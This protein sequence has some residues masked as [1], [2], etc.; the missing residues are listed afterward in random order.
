MIQASPFGKGQFLQLQSA[1][2]VPISRALS[3]EPKTRLKQA[4][5]L[6]F[7]G[8]DVDLETFSTFVG[9]LSSRLDQ[10]SLRQHF[11]KGVQKVDAGLDS[12]G[13]HCENGKDLATPDLCW[14]YCAKAAGMGS[15]TTL[16]DGYRVWDALSGDTQK[17]F[18]KANI[19]Y[20][21]TLPPSVWK[22]YIFHERPEYN[23]NNPDEI[24]LTHLQQFH[25][26]IENL[27]WRL[28][29]DLSLYTEHYAPAAHPTLFGT[30][31]AFANNIFSPSFNVG[32]PQTLW[33]NGEPL[34]PSIIQEITQVTGEMTEEV[35]WQDNDVLLIDNSRV[36]H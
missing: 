17:A 24:G 29:D 35:E 1:T 32:K 30:R 28:N 10:D 4:G 2:S 23:L 9:L 31:L 34:A 20:C 14:F 25:A 33:A 19:K 18:K 16:C 27:E 13:L 15:Q 36:M 5:A 11:A 6:L 8:F 7:R 21:R 22:N 12:V 3:L 26:N